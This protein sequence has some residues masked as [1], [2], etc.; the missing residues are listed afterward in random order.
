MQCG[1]SLYACAV[2]W[3]NASPIPGNV[4]GD[5]QGNH[6]MVLEAM[7]LLYKFNKVSK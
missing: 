6:I 1:V 7:S 2:S 3:Y 5:S 4:A